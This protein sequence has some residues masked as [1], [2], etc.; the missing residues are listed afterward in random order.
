MVQIRFEILKNL[1]KKSL[2]VKKINKNSL[3]SSTID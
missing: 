1:Q 2:N 3:K